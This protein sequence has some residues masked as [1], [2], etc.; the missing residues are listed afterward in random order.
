MPENIYVH[1]FTPGYMAIWKEKPI[2]KDTS[3]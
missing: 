3:E 2:V 1:V